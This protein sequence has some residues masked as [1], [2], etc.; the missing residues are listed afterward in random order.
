MEPKGCKY[1][2]LTQDLAFMLEAE[3]GISQDELDRDCN[4]CV[5]QKEAIIAAAE[6]ATDE[7][8]GACTP[9][10]PLL[11][12]LSEDFG[13][14]LPW[15]IYDSVD[16]ASFDHNAIAEG[17]AAIEDIRSDL[18]MRG[19]SPEDPM[20]ER[21]LAGLIYKELTPFDKFRSGKIDPFFGAWRLY[22]AMTAAG[23][24]ASFVKVRSERLGDIS[25]IHVG[26][27]ICVGDD[28]PIIADPAYELFDDPDAIAEPIDLAQALSLHYTHAAIMG[29]SPS[30][31][32]Q[33]AAMF[34]PSNY[35]AIYLQAGLDADEVDPFAE[36]RASYFSTFEYGWD[37]L[38]GLTP[39]PEDTSDAM[40]E[41]VFR[42]LNRNR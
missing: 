29:D 26:L 41:I 21:E 27:S 14:K 10:S 7:F 20:Y 4:G 11:T 13:I 6:I 12:M 18:A 24:D 32:L 17:M 28:D 37:V 1:D 23:L 38:Q 42:G 36:E 35:R 22:T 39:H 16:E 33:K 34:D 31:N 8:L 3:Y 5:S 9:T 15:I 25:Q 30:E 19:I 40:L 2:V